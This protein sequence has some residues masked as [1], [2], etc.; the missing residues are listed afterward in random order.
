MSRT[1]RFPSTASLTMSDNSQQRRP[2]EHSS[3][4]VPRPPRAVQCTSTSP[5][6]PAGAGVVAAA[7]GVVVVVV[8]VAV[9]VAWVVG[10]PT[11]IARMLVL[12]RLRRQARNRLARSANVPL[13]L[14]VG[15][16]SVSAGRPCRSYRQRKRQR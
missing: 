10:V 14:M 3:S 1:V 15:Q 11:P 13:S 5:A 16:T 4:S 7:A 12:V 8:E 6:G 2:S 9:E